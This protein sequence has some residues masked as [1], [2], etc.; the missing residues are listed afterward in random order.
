MIKIN[1][2]T[3]WSETIMGLAYLI[4]DYKAI[5]LYVGPLWSYATLA[6]EVKLHAAWMNLVAA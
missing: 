6:L 3:S 1:F 2:D 5:V 4:R